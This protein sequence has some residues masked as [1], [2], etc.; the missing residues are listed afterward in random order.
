MADPAVIGVTVT[1]VILAI[2]VIIVGVLCHKFFDPD[3]SELLAA[4]ASRTQKLVHN[5]RQSFRRSANRLSFRRRS[6]NFG[7]SG[8]SSAGRRHV[9]DE[10][11]TTSR[12]VQGSDLHPIYLQKSSKDEQLQQGQTLTQSEDVITDDDHTYESADDVDDVR[13]DVRGKY[14]DHVTKE[15]CFGVYKSAAAFEFSKYYQSHLASSDTGIIHEIDESL[16]PNS[17]NKRRTTSAGYSRGDQTPPSLHKNKHVTS[18]ATI[19]SQQNYASSSESGYRSDRHDPEYSVESTTDRLNEYNGVTQKMDLYGRGSD[20]RRQIPGDIRT[21]DSSENN[22]SSQRNADV[23]DNDKSFS[24][25]PGFDNQV[26]R[27]GESVR[28]HPENMNVQVQAYAGNVRKQYQSRD[29]DDLESRENRKSEFAIQ[30]SYDNKAFSGDNSY[31]N[32]GDVVTGENRSRSYSGQPG[33]YGVVDDQNIRNERRDVNDRKRY[34]GTM[35]QNEPIRAQSTTPQVHEHQNYGRHYH[36]ENRMTQNEP[37]RPRATGHPVPDDDEY[38][39]NPRRY[40]NEIRAIQNQPIRSKRTAPSVPNG[41]HE[42]RHV[43]YSQDTRYSKNAPT[44]DNRQEDD[45][46]ANFSREEKAEIILSPNSIDLDTTGDAG[47]SFM[48]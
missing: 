32:Y 20:Y 47:R 19:E 23:S 3:Q 26:Q 1:V 39:N 6:R 45:H 15:P 46:K 22:F 33:R 38:Q 36:N 7:R 17:V 42:R 13:E 34:H 31:V 14:G 40:H 27:N 29:V 21:I 12:V 48:V 11:E 41:E 16:S 24:K 28:H 35:I 30:S 37:I 2:I 5:F 4:D 43:V 8:R 44:L 25:Y 18:R 10:D 9:R